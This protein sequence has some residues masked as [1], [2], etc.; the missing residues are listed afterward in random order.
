MLK[1]LESFKVVSLFNYQG[2]LSRCL[3]AATLISYHFFRT[4]S[5]TF[6]TFFKFSLL[7]SNSQFMC[8]NRS[9]SQ[10]RYIT[11][12]YDNCQQLFHTF[13][14]NFLQALKTNW[15]YIRKLSPD[16]QQFFHSWVSESFWLLLCPFTAFSPENLWW[17]HAFSE[18]FGCFHL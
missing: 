14:Q 7:F 5:T 16:T 13:L 4:L 3:S 2:S 18:D 8:T 12:L 9:H 10:L 6:L 17:S 1:L 15:A 11:K